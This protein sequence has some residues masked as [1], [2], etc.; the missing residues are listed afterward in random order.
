MGRRLKVL[1]VSVCIFLNFVVCISVYSAPTGRGW[2]WVDWSAKRIRNLT[3]SPIFLAVTNTPRG[4]ATAGSHHCPSPVAARIEVNGTTPE[5]LWCHFTGTFISQL[6]RELFTGRAKHSNNN[7]V[8]VFMDDRLNLALWWAIPWTLYMLGDDWSL[9]ILTVSR[10]VYL[11]EQL[12][13]EFD[14]A[15]VYIDT[16]EDLYDF[17]PHI[18]DGF[19][20]HGQYY[21]TKQFWEGIRGEVVLLAQDHGVPMRRWNTPEA[22]DFFASV[23]HYW[24]M[25]APW[26]RATVNFFDISDGPRNMSELLSKLEPITSIDHFLEERA[27]R[28]NITANG[29]LWR[30]VSGGNG[31]FRLVKRS[32]LLELSVD[33]TRPRQHLLSEQFTQLQL[34]PMN[35]DVLWGLVLESYDFGTALKH[36]EQQ[37][38]AELI[39]S[40]RPYGIHNYAHYH[41]L[42]SLQRLLQC[43]THDFFCKEKD[44]L[45]FS[46][47]LGVLNSNW[48]NL[49]KRFPEAKLPREC[50]LTSFHE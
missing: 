8:V 32:K 25:A 37:F 14:L 29:R 44:I 19:F 4:S 36:V 24:Y 35:E 2:S 22:S 48:K 18:S 5:A 30:F 10:N 41:S 50:T 15:N 26:S 21:L 47:A 45:D 28:L 31:G 49:L 17:G 23:S 11:F 13:Q 33:M 42:D 27:S 39:D 34:S 7:K 38:S 20:A 1:V 3:V 16:A 6:N 9:Q 46:G 12:I 43:A 40:Q